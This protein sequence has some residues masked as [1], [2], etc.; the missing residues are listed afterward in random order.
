MTHEVDLELLEG[1]WIGYIRG[2]PG[3][4][5]SAETRESCLASLPAAIAGYGE[6]SGEPVARAPTVALGEAHVSWLLDADY[7]V[8][9]FF[10]ADRPP[11]S[12]DDVGRGLLLLKRSRAELLAT[13]NPLSTVERCREVEDGWSVERILRHVGGAEW[14]Y[15]DRLGLAPPRDTVPDDAMARLAFVRGQLVAALPGLTG[16]DLVTAPRMELWSPR[17]LLRRVLWHERDHTAHARQFVARLH[18]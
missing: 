2:L 15:L 12:A 6:W 1:R 9:A 10:A 13:I 8:N 16:S 14:W 3:C 7:E 4:F 11:L 17:K 5:A 18:Q